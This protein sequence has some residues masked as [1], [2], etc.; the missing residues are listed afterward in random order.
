VQLF[1]YFSTFYGTRRLITIFSCYNP[2]GKRFRAGGD[3]N[4]KHT[5]W[6]SR[7]NT[8]RGRVVYKTMERLY[9]RHLSTGEPTYWP[10]DKLLDLVD[11]CVTKDIPPTSTTAT[12]CLY[13]SSDHFPAPVSFANYPLPPVTPPHVNNRQTNWD[14]FRHPITERLTL[15]IPFKTLDD[16][17]E[18][19]KLFSDTV[20]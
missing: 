9:L 4:T 15:K 2:L 6:G 7:L 12:F 5:A 13:L 20:Q 10:S 17:E 14:L 19:V 1:K 8:P 3:Y 16:I 11:F 18:A